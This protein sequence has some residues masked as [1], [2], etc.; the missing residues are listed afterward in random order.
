MVTRENTGKEAESAPKI[1]AINFGVDLN[2][3]CRVG[4]WDEP[5]THARALRLARSS[6]TRSPATRRWQ[7]AENARTGAPEPRMPITVNDP[8]TAKKVLLL[9]A[10]RSMKHCLDMLRFYMSPPR[11][12]LPQHCEA[13]TSLSILTHAWT[14][15]D[16][17]L[18]YCPPF[19]PITVLFDTRNTANQLASNN[20]TQG[21]IIRETM[22][23]FKRN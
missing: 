20:R 19:P 22:A 18:K 10:V 6:L 1:T 8:R 7:P 9:N 4:G 14:I 2:E 21:Y 16:I 5:Q 3:L 13:P 15:N 23:H 12:S 17:G 11:P